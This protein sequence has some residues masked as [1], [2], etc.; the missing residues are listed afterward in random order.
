MNSFKFTYYQKQVWRR[1]LKK[2]DAPIFK[3]LLNKMGDLIRNFQ[4]NFAILL[5]ILLEKW[6]ILGMNT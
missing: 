4:P 2:R 5:A 1:S 3:T 6:H